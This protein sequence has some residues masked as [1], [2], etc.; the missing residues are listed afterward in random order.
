MYL[1]AGVVFALFEVAGIVVFTGGL[2]HAISSVVARDV[3][4][5]PEAVAWTVMGLAVR[6]LARYA[7]DVSAHAAGSAVKLQLRTEAVAALDV[8]W[9]RSHNSAHDTTVLANGIDALDDYFGRFIPQLVATAVVTPIIV[10]AMFRIDATSGLA[11]A[12]TLPLIPLFMALIGWATRTVQ[13]MQWHTLQALSVSFHEVVTGLPT[14]LAFGRGERQVV[15]IRAVTDDYRQR[16]MAVLRVSFLSGFA[17]EIGASLSVAIVAVFIGL[18]LVAGDMQLVDGL[19]ALLLAPEAFVA[20][21]QVGALF[22][23]SAEGVSAS[24]D[25]LAIIEGTSSAPDTTVVGPESVESVEFDALAV[26]GRL[27]AQSWAARSG[28]VTVV[29]GPSG[30]GKSTMFDALLGFTEHAGVVR[31]NGRDVPHLRSVGA[32]SP[33]DAALIAGTVEDNIVMRVAP[34]AANSPATIN[35]EALSLAVQRACLDDVPLTTVL[36]EG[37]AGV[38]GGQA[39]RI[40]L[41]RALYRVFDSGASVLIVDEPTSALDSDTEARVH[42]SLRTVA[43]E[44][45][46]VIA[47]SH[48]GSIRAIADQTIEVVA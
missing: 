25:V 29:H 46:I 31:C 2:A 18:R 1:A 28:T 22:H 34:D 27:S 9:V 20:V 48:R 7:T 8:R 17:L 3:A 5:V 35:I 26:P 33:Q 6:A 42:R 43:D 23:S 39:Q 45:R 36:G 41:A 12:I 11:V 14:L 10:V 30:A 32:W 16:T 37:G 21:R 13:D 38:S 44:G 4:R 19:W 47:S 24:A 15:R 40:S